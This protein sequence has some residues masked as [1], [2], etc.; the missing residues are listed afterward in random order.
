MQLVTAVIQP[1]AVTGVRSALAEIG[2]VGATISE[3]VGSG[4]Q[5]GHSEVYRGAEYP[6]SVVPKIR[7]EILARDE[8]V[9]EI[10]ETIVSSAR[11][12]NVGDGKI[13]T[14][15]VDEVIRVRTGTVGEGAI[16]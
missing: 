9:A 7:L 14:I 10:V 6:V 4:R 2:V 3:A 8:Q 13:W 15:P 12:G 11:T 1:S 16:Q 5:L